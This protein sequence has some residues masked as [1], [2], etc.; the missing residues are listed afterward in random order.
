[1]LSLIFEFFSR[2]HSRSNNLDETIKYFKMTTTAAPQKKIIQLQIENKIDFL[3]QLEDFKCIAQIKN[4]TMM[5]CFLFVT[6]IY[7]YVHIYIYIYI[8]IYI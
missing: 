6:D 7:I 5:Q 4:I 8:Y 2:E 1:M 3:F